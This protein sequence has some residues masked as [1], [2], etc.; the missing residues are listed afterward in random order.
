M[1]ISDYL[2]KL[3]TLRNALAD[4]L[5]AMGVSATHK[6]SLSALVPKVLDIP[7]GG[8]GGVNN[9]FLSDSDKKVLV[10]PHDIDTVWLISDTVLSPSLSIEDFSAPDLTAGGTQN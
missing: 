6:E 5:V 9:L 1:A 3:N 7:Q 2:A 4:N 8:D 10:M